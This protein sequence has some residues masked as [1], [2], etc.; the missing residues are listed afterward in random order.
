M[1]EAWPVAKGYLKIWVGLDHFFEEGSLLIFR[2]SAGL[3][4]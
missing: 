4:G 3:S 1:P 2:Q